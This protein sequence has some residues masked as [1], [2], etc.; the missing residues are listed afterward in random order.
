MKKN[1]NLFSLALVL[2]ATTLLT[3]CGPSVE[4]TQSYRKSGYT[5][6]RPNKIM[7]MAMGKNLASRQGA[8]MELKTQ[9]AAKGIK[10]VSYLE[11][12][13]NNENT[14][15][16]ATFNNT[17]YV[18]GIEGL[19][20]ARVVNVDKQ[21]VTVPGS[22]SYM[23]YPT[24]GYYGYYQSYYPVYNPPSTYVEVTTYIESNYYDLKDGS[25]AWQGTSRAFTDTYKTSIVRRWSE[26][27]VD[28]LVT[29][30][31]VI[32]PATAKP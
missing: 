5:T 21:T 6:S 7:V 30:K 12:F 29:M 16:S 23:S 15:D 14:V 25:T 26:E 1:L 2:T 27:L 13:P 10:A 8:E 22:T 19:F 28:D 20:T 18:N 11:L 9:F 31:K 17:L 3:S 4:L 24:Y 32:A